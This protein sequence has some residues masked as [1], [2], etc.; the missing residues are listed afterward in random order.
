[1]SDAK[2]SSSEVLSGELG[3]LVSEV[4][5]ISTNL[6]NAAFQGLLRLQ[7]GD[8]PKRVLVTRHPFSANSGQTE[9][10]LCP[11]NSSQRAPSQAHKLVCSHKQVQ[12]LTQ[13]QLQA[14][15]VPCPALAP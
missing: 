2:I 6:K 11:S 1:M 15:S 14:T 10:V 8:G 12:N 13:K 7:P 5:P 3:C 9:Q 4:E